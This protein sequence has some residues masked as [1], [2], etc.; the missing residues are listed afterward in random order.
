MIDPS[1]CYYKQHINIQNVR[2]CDGGKHSREH[3]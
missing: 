1:I 3:I 2:M